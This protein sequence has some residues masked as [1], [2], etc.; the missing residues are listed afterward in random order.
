MTHSHF[1][2]IGGND[3]VLPILE[4]TVI[5]QNVEMTVKKS[6]AMFK[7]QQVLESILGAE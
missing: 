1:Q 6:S 3:Y 5:H 4:M 2:N 7:L